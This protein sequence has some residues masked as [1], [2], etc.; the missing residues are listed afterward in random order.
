MP[1]LECVTAGDLRA[2]LLGT[3]PD[4]LS[5]APRPSLGKGPAFAADDCGLRRGARAGAGRHG[6]IGFLCQVSLARAM[7]YSWSV[8]VLIDPIGLL[9]PISR[10]RCLA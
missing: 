1:E 9:A 2:F 8:P 6:R 7:T 10:F 4:R 3:L 5:Q